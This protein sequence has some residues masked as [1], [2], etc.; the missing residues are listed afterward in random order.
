MPVVVGWIDCFVCFMLIGISG[1]DAG[2]METTYV[3][4]LTWVFG[5]SAIL[6]GAL[7]VGGRNGRIDGQ[8]LCVGSGLSY[9]VSE[10]KCKM[11]SEAVPAS[12]LLSSCFGIRLRVVWQSEAPVSRAGGWHVLLY[13]DGTTERIHYTGADLQ[14]ELTL[15]VNGTLLNAVSNS[16][17]GEC[18][19]R[20][21]SYFLSTASSLVFEPSLMRMMYPPSDGR[22]ETSTDPATPVQRIE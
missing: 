11:Q 4:W 17:G 14:D 19:I 18:N 15:Q 6:V 8:I 10:A 5:W 1:A 16:Q 7:D 2:G 22:L 9:F 3:T 21:T 13:R 20:A 12:V